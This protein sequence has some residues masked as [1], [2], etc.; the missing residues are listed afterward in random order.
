MPLALLPF[1]KAKIL[2]KKLV[3]WPDKLIKVSVS[4]SAKKPGSADDDQAH[5]RENRWQNQAFEGNCF[6]HL[7][8]LLG[9]PHPRLFGALVE[10]RR[11]HDSDSKA[12]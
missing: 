10:M 1:T 9:S 12:R 3:F 2:N 4:E 7:S 8:R 6:N 5:L 11:R